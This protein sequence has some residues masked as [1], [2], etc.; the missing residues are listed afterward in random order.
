MKKTKNR[1]KWSQGNVV[2]VPTNSIKSSASQSGFYK[3]PEN[4]DQIKDNIK[5]MGILVPLVVDVNSNVII[6]GN[7]RHKIALELD[8]SELPV[9]Y[10]D[11]E[12][13]KVKVVSISTNQFRKK[14]TLEILKEVEFFNDYFGVKQGV[15]T[16]LNPQ[17]KKLKAK[18]D[19]CIKG[20]SKDKLNKLTAIKK[21]AIEL[22]EEESEQ[23]KNVFDRIDRGLNSIN[24]VHKT[25]DNLVKTKRNK[26]KFKKDN[27]YKEGDVYIFNKS[28]ECMSE[29]EDNSIQTIVVSP[30][31]FQLVDYQTG[32]EQLGFESQV[33][34]YINNLITIFKEAKRV[35]KPEGSLFVNL[36][37]NIIDGVYQAVPQKFTLKMIELGFLFVDELL[38]IKRNPNRSPGKHSV[39]NHEPILHFVKTL[40]YYYDVSWLEEIL[41]KQNAISYGTN[42]TYPKLFSGLDYITGGVMRGIISSTADLRKKCAKEGFH[43]THQATFP[44]SIPSIAI[45]TTSKPGDKVLDFFNGTGSTGESALELKRSYYGY[46][47]N[48][49]YVEATKVRLRPYLSNDSE[50]YRK[51]A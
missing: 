14:S 12:P 47:T 1:D 45:L 4:Y 41:D 32:K 31:Y 37:D 8:I 3:I 30:P 26:G 28:A 24:S 49:E 11:I 40:K 35:L 43:L 10:D 46:E 19:E 16:D 6:S 2:V 33:D 39:R 18:R 44:L 29:I 22:Y 27:H 23:F 9:I 50:E 51:V 42:A 21:M 38:W 7:L 5:Q 48:P 13:D 25:L 34:E 17:S 15:R 36:N 20:I